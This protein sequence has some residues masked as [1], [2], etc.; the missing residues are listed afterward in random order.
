MIGAVS[1]G[2]N[3]FGN[4]R[5]SMFLTWNETADIQVLIAIGIPLTPLSLSRSVTLQRENGDSGAG[6]FLRA[7]EC[8]ARTSC[9]C[10][11]G[12][13]FDNFRV[14]PHL[15]T[16]LGFGISSF[17][18]RGAFVKAKMQGIRMCQKKVWNE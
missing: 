11:T 9:F 13:S 4:A 18:Q 15:P 16:A 17:R 12:A 1:S 7:A 10:S 2:H 6:S 8:E 3:G 14:I 5:R